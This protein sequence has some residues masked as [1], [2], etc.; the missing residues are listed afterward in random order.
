M[1]LTFWILI[2]TNSANPATEAEMSGK[3]TRFLREHAG[4]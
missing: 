3:R 4:A 2:I 1:W